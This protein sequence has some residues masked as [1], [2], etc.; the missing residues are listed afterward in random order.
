MTSVHDLTETPINSAEELHSLMGEASNRRIF[1]STQANQCSSRS[2]AVLQIKVEI[3]M[4]D[5][6]VQSKLYI[7]DLAGS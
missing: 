1:A 6:K 4:K 2:H 3:T 5:R 7:I